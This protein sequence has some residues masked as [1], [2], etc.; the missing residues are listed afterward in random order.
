MFPKRP[1]SHNMDESHKHNVQWKVRHERVNTACDKQN[2]EIALQDSWSW[3]H[4][5]SLVTQSNTNLGNIAKKF[6][7]FN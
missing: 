2:S 4:I 5:P 7:R 6:C 1:V 3:V